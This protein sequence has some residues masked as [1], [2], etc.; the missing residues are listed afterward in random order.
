MTFG[1]RAT[2]F[3]HGAPLIGVFRQHLG[4]P[5]DQASGGLVARSGQDRGIGEDLLARERPPRSCLVFELGVQEDGHQ[6]VG[7]VLGAPVDV[8]REHLPVRHRVF[9]DHH[10]LARFR[11]QVLVG[12]VADGNLVLF[13]YAEQH[14]D[15]PHREHRA[16]LGD[17]VEPVGADEGIEAADAVAAD[18]ILELGHPF[19]REDPRQKPT[20]GRVDRGILEHHHALGQRDVRLDDVE[21][22][23]VGAGEHP[24]VHQRPL[25][26]LVPGEKPE[27]V[28]LVVID[29]RLVAEPGIGGVGV[30]VDL[31]VVRVVV[32]ARIRDD[33]VLAFVRS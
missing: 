9:H 24:P 28:A 26:I 2:F 27:V 11:A 29:R 17:D 7:G 12:L 25:D 31:D 32:H 8:V 13:G 33:H 23:A 20:L 1:R 30:R 3:H 21:D 18:L 10:R 15:H 14:A 5:S 19:R 6:V 22:V 16:E 4:Q